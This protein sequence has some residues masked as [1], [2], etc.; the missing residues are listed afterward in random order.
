MK[1]WSN[2]QKIVDFQGTREEDNAEDCADF[3]V[4]AEMAL[5][6]EREP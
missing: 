3:R 4:S 2:P 5:G 6:R 1:P